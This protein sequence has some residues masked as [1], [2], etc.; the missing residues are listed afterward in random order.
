MDDDTYSATEKL[1]VLVLMLQQPDRPLT[2]TDVMEKTSY[3]HRH[4]QRI[5]DMLTE[6]KLVAQTNIVSG[7]EIAYVLVTQMLH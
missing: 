4:V 6:A 3:T 5:L 2:V 7:G 1:A